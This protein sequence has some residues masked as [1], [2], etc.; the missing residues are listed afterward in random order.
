[1]T[2]FREL[3]SHFGTIKTVD[4]VVSLSW[5]ETLA[6]EA[7]AGDQSPHG[8]PWHVS[9]HASAFPGNDKQA[10]PRKAAYELMDIGREINTERWLNQTAEVGKA[11]ELAQVRRL[12][13]AGRLARSNIPGLS[14]DPDARDENGNPMPQIGF[15]DKEHW[16]TGSV[17]IAM[18]VFST[19]RKPHIVEVKCLAGETEVLTRGGKRKI[20]DLAGSEAEVINGRGDW[21]LVPFRQFGEDRLLRIELRTAK[22]KKVIYANAD[23]RWFV[24]E[25]KHRNGHPGSVEY[26]TGELQPGMKLVRRAPRSAITKGGVTVPSPVGIARGLVY[27]DGSV[28][29]SGG[30][31]LLDLFEAKNFAFMRYFPEA[32]TYEL[33][34]GGLRVKGFPKSYKTER[35]AFDE[36]V[37]YLYGWLAGYFGADGTVAKNGSVFLDSV[38]RSS[39]EYVQ[40]LCTSLGITT[41]Q[42]YDIKPYDNTPPSGITLKEWQ[43]YR[44]KIDAYTLTEEFF[45]VEEHRR[46]WREWWEKTDPR[47]RQHHW[48]VVSVE[49]TDRVEPVYCAIVEGSEQFVL[50]GFILTG[51]TKHESQIVDMMHGLRGP[52]A[53]HEKQA[54]CSLGMAHNHP[55]AFLHPTEDRV[56]DPPTDG[57]I[58]YIARDS[59]WQPGNTEVLN[60]EFLIEHNDEFMEQGLAH[61]KRFKQAFLDNELVQEVERKNA[62]SHPMGW[63]WSKGPCE[64]CELK[65]QCKDDYE[66]NI[67]DLSKS[68]AY[69][70]AK[71]I[72]TG[73]DPVKAR[74]AVLDFWDNVPN[75]ALITDKK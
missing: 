53:K 48:Q 52:D 9:F 58:Y 20:A 74:K 62:R 67:T 19:E 6:A 22:Q 44:L 73:Y 21:Q 32:V 59:K 1:M 27:G 47:K 37:S 57:T 13:D 46:R 23:H 55:G 3:L 43:T 39:L 7:A 41:R 10:C 2:T 45:I 66:N 54:R 26:T 63:L 72:R 15:I 17:D 56:L 11:I 75:E 8:R 18:T 64:R 5:D 28:N 14:T 38:D 36:G 24:V 71:S 40:D 30:G 16:L 12:R 51:N 65:K 34:N 31:S 49:S 33:G 69:E 4:P 29:Y 50:D 70:V 35:P 68:S 25:G 42:I 61:L 60:H